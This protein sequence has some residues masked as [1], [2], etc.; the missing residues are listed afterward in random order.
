MSGMWNNVGHEAEWE[1]SER[2]LY[3]EA[4]AATD[5]EIADSVFYSGPDENDR[6]SNRQIVDDLSQTEDWDGDDVP[7]DELIRETTGEIPAGM[8]GMVPTRADDELMAENRALRQHI[9]EIQQNLP[10][11]QRAALCANPGQWCEGL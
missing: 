6:N 4:V 2:E 10:E 8:A 11:P 5:R 7:D 9:S 1:R 3:S